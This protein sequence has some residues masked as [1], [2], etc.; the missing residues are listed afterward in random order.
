VDG[1]AAQASLERLSDLIGMIYDCALDPAK[2]EPTLE[3]INREFSFASCIL[4]VIAPGATTN[5]CNVAVGYDPEWLALGGAPAYTLESIALWGGE[6]RASRFPLDEPIVGSQTRSYASRRSNR[7]FVD[8]LEPRGIHD[9]MIMTLAR[10]PTLM[11]YA[12]FNRHF[13]AGAIGEVEVAAMRLLGPHFRRAVTIS[14]LFDLKAVDASRFA[15]TLDAFTFGVVLVGAGA[16]ILH[17][18]AAARSMLAA[19]DPIRSDRGALALP[20]TTSNAALERAVL[21]AL[22]DEAAMGGRGIAIPVRR[23]EGEPCLVHVLPL[24]RGEVRRGIDPQAAAAVFIAPATSP[25]RMP[26]DALALLYDL[27]PAETRVFELTTAGMTPAEVG[28]HL[29]IARS[30]AKTHLLRVFEKTGCKRQADLGR[31]AAR[32]SLPT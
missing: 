23:A 24:R 8:V 11:G 5:R 32:L 17:A 10:E 27:T 31:L 28:E 21:Q 30:T 12:G 19:R 13:S 7:Y 15:S 14:N 2:W 6:E 3:N 4:G 1:R 16:R 9:G 26:A 18:N 20:S 22:N 25:G 29:G